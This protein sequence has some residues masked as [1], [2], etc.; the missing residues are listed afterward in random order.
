MKFSA[1]IDVELVSQ[2]RLS[3]SLSIAWNQHIIIQFASEKLIFDKNGQTTLWISFNYI[4][5]R[6]KHNRAVQ[7]IY[8]RTKQSR[9][10]TLNLVFNCKAR[11][12][13]LLH[14]ARYVNS[15]VYNERNKFL[16]ILLFGLLLHLPRKS[17]HNISL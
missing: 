15:S 8:F 17:G 6:Y 4:L 14:Q 12:N 7:H 2:N 3:V 13:H 11:S 16:D 1:K 5:P 9:Y 10:R